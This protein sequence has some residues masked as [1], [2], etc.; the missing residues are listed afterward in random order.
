MNVKGTCKA[1]GTQRTEKSKITIILTV[2]INVRRKSECRMEISLMEWCGG[3]SQGKNVQVYYL[4]PHLQKICPLWNED[5][6]YGGA[7]NKHCASEILK[8]FI[9]QQISNFCNSPKRFYSYLK[10]FSRLERYRF[11]FPIFA[12][13]F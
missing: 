7:T 8:K 12:R 3:G 9:I 5:L 10:Y 6:D 11:Q 13:T 1:G 4:F 2:F